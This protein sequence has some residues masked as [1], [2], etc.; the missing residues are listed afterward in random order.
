M[1]REITDNIF[2][3]HHK[4]TSILPNTKAAKTTSGKTTE[5]TP[6]PRVEA[7]APATQEVKK[8]KPGRPT[9]RNAMGRGKVPFTKSLGKLKLSSGDFV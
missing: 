6:T 8:V 1:P 7:V 3:W 2:W 9:T 5:Q 4:I